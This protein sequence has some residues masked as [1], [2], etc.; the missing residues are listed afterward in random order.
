[1]SRFAVIPGGRAETVSPSP[2]A[3]SSAAEG[4]LLADLYARHAGAVLSRCRWLLGDAEA[5]KD[6]TQ[7]VFTRAL[8]ALPEFRAA[9]SPSTWLLSIA[10]HHCLNELRAGRA[11]WKV[12]V[13][14]LAELKRDE[15]VVPE[16][17]ELVR[18]LLARAAPEEQEVAVMYYV[19]ELTQAEIA[20]ATGRS[21]PTVRKRLRGFLAAARAA[22]AEAFPELELP[23]EGDL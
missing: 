10:T 7:D 3:P 22:L 8:R 23:E 1:M 14:R 5:A 15:G 21:L 17:R 6:A 11:R 13:V 9:A 19:D 20:A 16:K 2:L 18:A 12:E 4:G